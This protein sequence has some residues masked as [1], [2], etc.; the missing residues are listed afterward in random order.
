MK[1][2]LFVLFTLMMLQT[3][4]ARTNEYVILSKDNKYLGNLTATSAVDE[5][6]E[7]ISV[8]SKITVKKLFKVVFTYT[9]RS[10]FNG[11]KL[12]LNQITTYLNDKIK[13]KMSTVKKGSGYLFRK[14]NQAKI[15]KDFTFCESMMY[16]NEPKNV[17]QIYSEF[18]G[19]L[20]STEYLEREKCYALTNP[21]NNNVSKYF[22]QDGVLSKAIVKNAF[23][24]LYLHLKIQ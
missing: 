14:N 22:Y 10:S 16:Y 13:D 1:R 23:T 9:L 3:A 6:T 7:E 2:L 15:I 21:E 12:H 19:V 8:E 24:T 20:K 5:E 11:G 17:K 4:Q 18:D